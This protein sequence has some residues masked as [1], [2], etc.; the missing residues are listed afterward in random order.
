M[1][2]SPKSEETVRLGIG[3]GKRYFRGRG[4]IL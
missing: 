3:R 4:K 1:L 2:N